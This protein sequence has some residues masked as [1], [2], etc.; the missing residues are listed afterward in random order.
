MITMSRSRS[1]LLSAAATLLIGSGAAP[2]TAASVVFVSDARGQLATVD[3]GSGATTIIG[4]TGVV[5]TDIAFSPGGDLFGIDFTNLYRVN[6]STA[7][8]TLIGPHSI[9]GGNALAFDDRGTLLAA[10]AGTMQLFSIDTG[11]GLSTVLGGTGFAAAGD[12]AFRSGD[13]FLSSRSNQLVRIDV[14]TSFRGMA[15]GPLGIASVLALATADM[16][17]LYGI[18]GTNIFLI[19]PVTGQAM[20]ASSFA[21]M[22]LDRAFGATFRA[23]VPEPSSALLILLGLVALRARRRAA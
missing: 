16:D 13:L 6:A 5:L 8:A 20:L 19:D 15:V 18:S 23:A 9:P 21:G 17:Q 11:T 14:A 4:S 12:L 22:Q 3:V 10:A 7:E 1:F 2:A